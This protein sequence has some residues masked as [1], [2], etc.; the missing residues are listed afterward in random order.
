MIA[1]HI[2]TAAKMARLA[3]NAA[4]AGT[5]P[6]DAGEMLIKNIP[7]NVPMRSKMVAALRHYFE[8]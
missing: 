6:K 2:D 4:K 7:D 5:S 8:E 3:Y 1:K